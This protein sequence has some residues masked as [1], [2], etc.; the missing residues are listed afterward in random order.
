MFESL[1]TD[2][3]L[4]KPENLVIALSPPWKRAA[5][6]THLDRRDGTTARL[7]SRLVLKEDARTRLQTAFVV[8]PTTL[9]LIRL[10]PISQPSWPVSVLLSACLTL[11]V[12]SALTC[13][14]SRL[15]EA[16][17]ET[18]VRGESAQYIGPCLEVLQTRN[19][20]A[21]MRDKILQALGRLLPQCTQE[22]FDQ[23]TPLQRHSLNEL[24]NCDQR[25]N[26][27]PLHL[28]MLNILGQ[29][30]D[31]ASLGI[32]YRQATMETTHA[33]LRRAARENVEQISR[34]LDFGTLK[35]IP[36][37]VG[38]LGPQLYPTGIDYKECGICIMALR[39]LVPQL[40]PENVKSVLS[41]S[42][43]DS[44]YELLVKR[45]LYG[46]HRYGKDELFL[47]I[48][49]AAGRLQDTRA[50]RALQET[51]R[52]G[53]PTN[54]AK[55]LRAAA[56]ET[57]RALQACLEKQKESRVL[58]RG[59][60]PPAHPEEEL[61]RAAPAIADTTAPQELLRVAAPQ[62]NRAAESEAASD[63]HRTTLLP[64]AEES[65]PPLQI[66]KRT[67]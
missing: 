46:N 33:L 32:V 49:A 16:A 52:S 64:N 28:A 31:T 29:W 11:T 2:Q 15:E 24:A 25:D 41:E 45:S 44:L 34:R 47:E 20:N 66:G 62:E 14:P 56:G 53:A 12:A 26:Y 23:F 61:L 18:L 55:R 48:I 63:L 5:M 1:E 7:L 57:C 13:R 30:G 6:Q 67:Q 43:R 21:P 60:S 22:I 3:P 50:I 38:R 19:L 10:A 17:L 4:P 36:E 40:T 42:Q 39:R 65:S 37:Y 54:E 27:V 51:A 8:L 58:L 35:H 9:I 59:A